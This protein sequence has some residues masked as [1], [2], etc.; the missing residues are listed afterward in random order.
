MRFTN[1]THPVLQHSQISIKAN[2]TA[3]GAS[4]SVELQ[5]CFPPQNGES[6]RTDIWVNLLNLGLSITSIAL[7]SSCVVW[8]S[9]LDML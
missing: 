7:L 4:A 6:S 2:A 5:N 8:E 1:N 3:P 9:R